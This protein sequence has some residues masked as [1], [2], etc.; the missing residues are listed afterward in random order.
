VRGPDVIRIAI[1]V[2]AAVGLSATAARAEVTDVAELF[3][4]G[5]LAYAEVRNP[6]DV[7]KVVAGWVRGT[8]FEDGLR[9]VHDRRDAIKDQNGRAGQSTVGAATLLTSPEFLREI[10]RFGGAA[11]G[12]TGFTEK[13]EPQMAAAVLFGDSAAGSLLARAFLTEGRD[14]RRVD[15]VEGVPVFQ[16]RG[17]AP[18]AFGNDGKPIPF[19]NPK[20]TEGSYEATY[21][22]RP[23]LFVVGTSKA[24]VADTL[25]R[26]AGPAGRPSL[27]KTPE[28][29][30][31]A[32]ERKVPGAFIYAVPP[33]LA[34]ELDSARKVNRLTVD[35]DLLAV[36]NFVASPKAFRAAAVTLTLAEDEVT[37]ALRADI[38]AGHPSPLLGLFTGTADKR[39][40]PHSLSGAAG[41]TTLTLPGPED[42]VQAVVAIADSWAKAGGELGALPSQR[43]AALEKRIGV[44]IRDDVLQRLTAVTLIAPE[45][46]ELPKGVPALPVVILHTDSDA[47]TRVLAEALPKLVR[48]LSDTDTTPY[49]AAE[50]VQG[51]RVISIPAVE[52]AGCPAT[53]YSLSKQG[54]VIGVDRK[55]V[56]RVT[57]DVRVI[58]ADR[59]SDVEPGSA[60][61]GTF[62]IAALL[63]LARVDVRPGG[64]NSPS[65]RAGPGR[66]TQLA[67]ILDALPEMTVRA[68][69]AN[70]RLSA[71]V[72]ARGFRAKLPMVVEKLVPWLEQLGAEAGQ[73]DGSTIPR[74]HLD[75]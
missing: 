10:G 21:A 47:D 51:T 44:R 46:Q 33:A 55:W 23:G 4:E 49:T 48:I 28:F 34:K 67:D 40:V 29:G 75:R 1:L 58:G 52:A 59:S 64:P 2:L 12:L 69:A 37:L 70:G 19:E 41:V 54:V 65:D 9:L 50:I 38:V 71:T 13:G 63:R 25:R 26:H 3:P 73:G 62:R 39:L 5:T 15:T 56:A 31:F 24:I 45:R 66:V 6:G 35:G 53:H 61:T 14:F 74:L 11:V 68:G 18:P 17:L 43:L 36:F 20:P 42:R 60:I 27:A 30:R 32:V 8:R 57:A 7:A 16:R 22:Y 72:T